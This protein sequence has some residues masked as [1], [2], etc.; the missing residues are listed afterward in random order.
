MNFGEFLLG[1]IAIVA[2]YSLIDKYMKCNK[3]D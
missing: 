3:K 1:L 2:I